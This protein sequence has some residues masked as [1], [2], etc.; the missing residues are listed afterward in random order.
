MLKRGSFRIGISLCLAA[1]LGLLFLWGAFLFLE[2]DPAQQWIQRKVSTY[3]KGRFSW[4]EIH[5]SWIPGR[6]DI[7][8]ILLENPARKPVLQ[9]ERLFV[10]FSWKA[11]LSGTLRIETGTVSR[12]KIHLRRDADGTLDLVAA[13]TPRR[14]GKTPPREKKEKPLFP[15]N[16]TIDA[17]DLT[18]GSF[19]FSNRIPGKTEEAALEKIDVSLRGVDLA[20]KSGLLTARLG[21]GTLN[22]AG[23]KSGWDTFR[24]RVRMEKGKIRPLWARVQSDLLTMNIRGKGEDLME[25]PRID[26]T[27]KVETAL[28]HLCKT[29]HVDAAFAGPVKLRI[30]VRGKTSNP[31]IRMVLDYGGGR[32]HGIETKPFV[33]ES[34]LRDRAL[35][36][37]AG[38][39]QSALGKAVVSGKADLKK[40]F[41]EG[42]LSAKKDMDALSF[43]LDMGLEE[44]DLKGLFETF[45]REAPLEGTLGGKI[46]VTGKGLTRKGLD[47]ESTAALWIEGASRTRGAAPMDLKLFART[48]LSNQTVR[49]ESAAFHVGKTSLTGSGV[50]HLGTGK[51]M[52]RMTL[53]VP[54][55]GPMGSFWGNASLGGALDARVRVTGTL[56]KLVADLHLEGR[57]LMFENRRADALS[58]DLR[59]EQGRIH[60][61]RLQLQEKDARLSIA[62]S[63]GLLNP[64]TWRLIQDP[65]LELSFEGR[66][67]NPE[68]FM[69][70]IRGTFL[71]HGRLGGTFH[72]PEG[73]VDMEGERLD[74]FGQKI[75]KVRFRA[76]MR[77]RRLH[78]DAA[79]VWLAADEVLEGTGWLSF[80]DKTFSLSMASEGLSLNRIH[81]LARAG[82][83]QGRATLTVSGHGSLENPK[84]AGRLVLTG[85]RIRGKP[86]EAI[87]VR[88]SLADQVVR[89]E[90]RSVFDLKAD[91]HITDLDFKAE[92]AVRDMNLAPY[93]EMADLGPWGGRLSGTLTCK[94]NA[95][96]LESIQA[97]GDLS[98]LDLFFKQEAVLRSKRFR[99]LLA[100]SRITASDVRLALLQRGNVILR[101]DADLKG[102]LNFS[103]QA[104]IPL[105][106]LHVFV[107]QLKGA[108]GVA[109]CTASIRGRVSRPEISG[110]LGLRQVRLTPPGLYQEIRD[111]R[112]AITFTPK[113]V[114][115]ERLSGKM[116]QGRFEIKG[117]M[118]LDG[119]TP[120][121]ADLRFKAYHLSWNIPEA[122]DLTVDSRLS[123]TGKRD[124]W[125]LTGEILLTEGIY[126]KNMTLNLVQKDGGKSREGAP[127][128][129]SSLPSFLQ[130]VTLDV[131][132]GQKAP[133]VV[134][135]NLA[136]LNID[137]DL[138]LKGTLSR[139]RLL[140]RARVKEGT[141]TFL[142]REFEITRGDIDFINPYRIEPTL[143]IESEI[144]VRRWTILL[145][146]TGTPDNL[147]FTKT[148]RP[149]E[150]EEDILMLLTVGKTRRE[151]VRE[152]GGNW[153]S[154][155]ALAAQ[156]AA[157]LV[158]NRFKEATGMDIFEAKYLEKET[159]TQEEGVEVTVGKALSRRL[160]VKYTIENRGGETTQRA[161]SEYRWM[162]NV[163]AS[164][165][166]ENTGNYGVQILY[167]LEFR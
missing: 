121:S 160:T 15:F 30:R 150:T 42:L 21:R 9:V 73:S 111:A 78:L 145:K 53:S 153:I 98:R 29:F 155:K 136:L 122:L 4:S 39:I 118:E 54:D 102:D 129:P 119:L 12:P 167:R 162:E 132:I 87:R 151:M 75:E 77:G 146:V 81:W 149:P 51:M 135:N 84:A 6:I 116:G 148:S 88:A 161:S 166:Q 23:M 70:G 127:E 94:G 60:A 63:V 25:D 33:L 31:K 95:R 34:V 141:V 1:G 45:K 40:A 10:D 64:E 80:S 22:M 79:S 144:H 85:I 48:R 134:D 7:R 106:G 113:G 59:F 101:G 16:V 152:E 165:F 103:V 99:V 100:G 123:L 142:G 58:A 17:F 36:V 11:L 125:A 133:F 35:T 147:V 104:A 67:L 19:R 137:S 128:S 32:L 57:A 156:I 37:T 66:N 13:L 163:A 44:V 110:T 97:Q 49:V 114:V 96:H 130:K 28:E 124:Q 76:R 14:K 65:S 3:I 74:V 126:Y 8:H 117:N 105:K 109:Q 71:C 138:Q 41:P 93:F 131:S 164:A 24:F 108:E 46:A 107:P 56:P 50:Y 91:V 90:A 139:P 120:S 52:T 92:A 83:N 140:G 2:S 154:S 112:A 5:L 86:V 43:R 61:R 82:M 143:D 18:G 69:E 62:G 26:M 55:L 72:R 38:A 89:L 68:D 115:V 47:A 157:G 20:R 27:L 159:L 158:E